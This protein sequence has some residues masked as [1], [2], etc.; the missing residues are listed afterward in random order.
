MNQWNELDEAPIVGKYHVRHRIEAAID[1]GYMFGKNFNTLFEAL[2]FCILSPYN[3][4]IMF[5][6]ENDQWLILESPFNVYLMPH[7]SRK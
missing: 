4:R 7:L 6:V 1:T 3:T 5:H 2:N